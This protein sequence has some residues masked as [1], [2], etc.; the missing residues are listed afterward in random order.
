MILKKSETNN[1]FH[2]DDSQ[3]EVTQSV[4]L[5]KQIISAKL[6]QENAENNSDVNHDSG[7]TFDSQETILDN[8]IYSNSFLD[9]K[10]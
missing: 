9:I 8:E 6:F 5:K 7:N 3:S 4:M 10:K 2:G 1:N